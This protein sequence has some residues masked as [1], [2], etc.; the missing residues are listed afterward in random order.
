MPSSRLGKVL[1]IGAALCVLGALLIVL[2][3]HYALSTYTVASLSMNETLDEGD[4]VLV[5]KLDDSLG[6]VQRGDI[7]ILDD[8]WGLGNLATDGRSMSVVTRVIGLPGDRVACCDAQQRLTVNGV[9]LVEPYVHPN[10]TASKTEFDVVVEPDHLW[11][12]GDHRSSSADSRHHVGDP[13]HGGVAAETLV[14]TV[15]AILASEG[16]FTRVSVPESIDNEA[17]DAAR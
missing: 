13:G 12:M 16:G 14:G 4:K 1:L 8:P 11:V 5:N 2:V 7:V 3:W 9:P 6:D 15:V 10:D 17:I